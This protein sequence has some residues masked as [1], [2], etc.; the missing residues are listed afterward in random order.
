MKTLPRYAP[1]P[2]ENPLDEGCLRCTPSK[3]RSSLRHANRGGRQGKEARRKGAIN[4][5]LNA[6]VFCT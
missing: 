3:L 6:L 4:T 2:T 5:P 1:K